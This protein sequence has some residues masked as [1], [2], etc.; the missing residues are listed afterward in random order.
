MASQDELI[1]TFELHHTKKVHM[2]PGNVPSVIRCPIQDLRLPLKIKIEYI[3]NP[4]ADLTI[5]YSFKTSDP[6]DAD[7]FKKIVNKP[8]KIM[9]NDEGLLQM[10]DTKG[11][12]NSEDQI[13]IVLS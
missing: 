12:G 9:I 2:L 11:F 5:H 3:N 13:A 4:Q 7:C 6:N 1:Q 8:D 10:V